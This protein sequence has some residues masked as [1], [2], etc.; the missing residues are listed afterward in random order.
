MEKEDELQGLI[1]AAKFRD[2]ESFICDH[3]MEVDVSK[4]GWVSTAAIFGVLN[5]DIGF[6]EFL[7]KRDPTL[8]NRHR[9]QSFL[10][11]LYPDRSLLY[12]ACKNTGM[13]DMVK[14]LL[15]FC[16]CNGDTRIS[17]LLQAVK[18]GDAPMVNAL[19]QDGATINEKERTRGVRLLHIAATRKEDP[20]NAL[21]LVSL[22]L[23]QTGRQRV[24]ADQLDAS[25]ETALCV[26]TRHK[27]VDVAKTLRLAGETPLRSSCA[28]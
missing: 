16:D 2:A 1:I 19:L 12:Y 13:I 6:L 3:N 21:A 26:A 7:R 22:L 4:H 9:L 17:P 15:E 8:F 14:Y 20:A 24:Y 11:G 23:S 5:G 28:R 18:T 27:L 10:I 25:G